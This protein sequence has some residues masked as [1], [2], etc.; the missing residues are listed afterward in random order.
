[1]TNISNNDIQFIRDW[2]AKEDHLPKDFTDMMI[3]KFLHSCYGS[4][5]QTKQC[6]EKFCAGR[7]NMPELY[8]NRDPL[9]PRVL[10]ANS[11][12]TVATYN[13]EGD[14]ILIHQLYDPNLEKFDFY[15]VLKSFSLQADYWI[16]HYPV[17]ADGH[18]VLLDIQHYFLK[19]IPKVNIFYFRHFLLY[20]IEAMPVRLKQVHV[21][22]CPSYYEKL[23]LLV[24]PVLPQEIC[25]IIHFHP[26]L[27]SLHKVIDKKYLP[28][29]LGGEAPSMKTQTEQWVNK[30]EESRKTYLNDNLW[31]GLAAKKS[32]SADNAMNGS[33]RTL[34][35]D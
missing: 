20:L 24:K 5:E 14:E 11:I 31:K 35:I 25:D 9:S 10:T 32:K 29:E 1:M 6:I 34:S 16:N 18:I 2:M 15:D 27:E 13:I 3:K 12:T 8:T 19:I 26:N 7:Q 22:N 17:F 28:V 23:Y 21:F 33:F 30:I 4:L